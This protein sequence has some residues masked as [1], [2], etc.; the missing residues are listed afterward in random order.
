MVDIHSHILPGLDDG[1]A[2]FDESLAMLRMA[3]EQGTTDIVATP[4]ANNEYKFE[5]EIIGERIAELAQAVEGAIR[6]HCGCDFH[7]SYD[8]I[9]DALRHPAKYAINHKRYILVEFSDFLI[10]KTTGEVFGRMQALGLIPV[11]THPER[12]QL[13]QGRLPQLE[14]WTAAGCLLQVTAQSFLGRFGKR[15]K[16]FSDL[17]LS[18]GLVHVVASD[19]HDTTQ[20]PPVL[21]E[22]YDYVAKQCGDE[23]AQK[24]FV[25]NPAATLTGESIESAP[26]EPPRMKKWYKLWA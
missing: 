16:T 6:I 17:L 8:N 23:W 18:R 7:L 10:P 11:I 4:H 2:S 15:A 1:A 22:A 24:L 13:L 12:N 14:E 21:R 19:A 26:A 20:R 3:A 9:E 25:K 5:P